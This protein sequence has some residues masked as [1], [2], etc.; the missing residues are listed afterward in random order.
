M[1]LQIKIG[2]SSCLLGNNV[3]YDGGNKLDRYLADTL[4]R[5]V[6]YVPVCPEVEYGLPVPREPMH[7]EG[8]PSS[9]RLVT[10]DTHTDYTAKMTEWAGTRMAG[11]EKEELCGFVFKSKSPSCG[12]DGIKVYPETGG[13]ADDGVGIFARSFMERFPFL[14]V[15]DE[16][17]LQDPVIRERFIERVFAFKR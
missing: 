16:A 7:L 6:Q 11:L 15:E 2:I 5:F 12:I 9:P 10:L 13:P 14:P 3:R 8:A 1:E 17:R 4:G